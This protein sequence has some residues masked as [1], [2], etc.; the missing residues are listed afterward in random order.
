MAM[1]I[2][3]WLAYPR[4]EW[5]RHAPPDAPRLHLGNATVRPAGLPEKH[6]DK[7]YTQWRAA[8]DS[9]RAEAEAGYDDWREKFDEWAGRQKAAL[10]KAWEGAVKEMGWSFEG[11]GKPGRKAHSTVRGEY[12][13][14]DGVEHSPFDLDAPGLHNEGGFELDTLPVGVPL[15]SRYYPCFLDHEDSSGGLPNPLDLT[16]ATLTTR[17]RVAKRHI[18]AALPWME[19]ARLNVV[20]MHY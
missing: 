7:Q 9:W 3:L 20:L 5:E 8:C 15:S 12:P 2:E 10:R 19:L 18:T 11:K 4:M 6:T 14:V 16:D 17:V 13:A 1:G